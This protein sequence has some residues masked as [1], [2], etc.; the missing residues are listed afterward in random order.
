[1]RQ[2]LAATNERCLAL[3]AELL[4]STVDT[5]QLAALAKPS[6]IGSRRIPGLKLQD[7]RVIRLLETLLH[8]GDFATDWTTRELLARVVA[9]HRLAEADYRLSQLRYDLTKLRAKGLDCYP[10]R[11]AVLRPG[12]ATQ[13]KAVVRQYLGS[14]TTPGPGGATEHAESGWGCQSFAGR[15]NADVASDTGVSPQAIAGT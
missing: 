11:L 9:R 4:A 7:D 5:G 15:Q 10:T 2:K 6:V 13:R 12:E 3:Q 1:L 8:P 14:R